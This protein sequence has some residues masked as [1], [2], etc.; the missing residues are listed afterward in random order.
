MI[1]IKITNYKNLKNVQKI[2]F[3]QNYYWKD[4]NQNYKKIPLN[5]D[6]AYIIIGYISSNIKQLTYILNPTPT[7]FLI[8][9]KNKNVIDYIFIRKYKLKKLYNTKKQLINNN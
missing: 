4:I 7:F 3:N 6:N 2:L 8:N 9:T 5:K 1:S